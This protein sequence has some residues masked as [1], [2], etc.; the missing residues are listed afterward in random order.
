[1]HDMADHGHP[2]LIGCSGWSYADWEGAF[3]PQAMVPVDYLGWYADHFPVV[4]VDSSFYRV[5]SF[6]LVRGWF[7]RTPEGFRFAL[8]VPRAITHDKQ[9]RD[10]EREVAEFVDAVQGLG[11]KLLVAI[12]QLGYFP[13]A[14][15]R[16]L[17]N[18]LRVLDPFLALWPHDRVPLALETR[19]ARWVAPA[20]TDVL[21]AHSTS[22]VLTELKRMPRPAEVTS[23][24]DPLTGPL[25]VI[26]LLGDRDAAEQATKRFDRVVIDRTAEMAETARVIAT[27]A[28]RAP[29]AVFASNHYA[30]FAPE[31]ARELRGMLGLPEPVVPARPKTTLFD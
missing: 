19:N 30:G 18:F 26:R 6:R 4:E 12:L 8:K 25:G 15:F 29:V 22:L 14:A 21:R 2:I 3:Y 31:T 17:D 24:L 27:L 13:T 9:L 10:C 11:E 23:R 16:T 20:L 28:E 5:P 1:M 7:E